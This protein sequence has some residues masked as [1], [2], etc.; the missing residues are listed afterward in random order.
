MVAADTVRIFSSARTL[1]FRTW[2]LSIDTPL[3]VLLF[4]PPYLCG[5]L[6]KHPLAGQ[7]PPGS[8]L[9]LRVGCPTRDRSRLAAAVPR[10]RH[11]CPEAPVVILA[12]PEPGLAH[13]AGTAT[14]LHVRAVLSEEEPIADTLRHIL[15]DPLDF[16]GDAVE[17]LRLRKVPLSSALSDTIGLIFREAPRFED[18]GDLLAAAGMPATTVRY[19]MR[20]KGLPSPARWFQLARAMR[21]TLRLQSQPQVG[22]LPCALSLGFADQSAICQLLRRTFDL[23]PASIRHTLGWEWLMERW[24]ALRGVCL[25]THS[26]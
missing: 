10:L 7:L 5:E 11:L 12:P 6:I 18:V 9:V 21:V 1:A 15:T 25:T 13:L 26:R 24:L 23:P 16:A 22:L 4:Q 19:R 8:V 3:P 2:P 14:K 20:K 17:W